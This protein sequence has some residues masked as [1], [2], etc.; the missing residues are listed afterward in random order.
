MALMSRL[1][2]SIH[3]RF[4]LPLFL[5]PGGT[6]SRVFLLTCSWPRLFT[7][8]NHL[9]CFP[10]PLCYVLYFQ[11]LPDVIVYGLFSVWPHAHLKTANL[12]FCHFEFL[13]AGASDW[14]CLHPVQHSWLNDHLCDETK[15]E[16]PM[17]RPRQDE[18]SKMKR[19]R[20]SEWYR[21]IFDAPLGGATI[22]IHNTVYG[23][24]ADG[25]P[26]QDLLLVN[27]TQVGTYVV[28]IVRS[29]RDMYTSTNTFFVRR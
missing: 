22:R 24:A 10:T 4:G 6:I 25:S 5:L 8:P 27:C 2:Q 14:H 13:H 20:R 11:P 15:M 17:K 18:E 1:T 21:L 19:P 7:W 29:Y 23:V 26:L 16:T 12:H 3:L 28:H 9:S